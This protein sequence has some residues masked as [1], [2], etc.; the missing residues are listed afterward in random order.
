MTQATK[1]TIDG[2]DVS[3]EY[4]STSDAP[5]TDAEIRAYIDRGNAQHPEQLCDQP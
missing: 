3:I 4:T 5:V 2:V 1:Q